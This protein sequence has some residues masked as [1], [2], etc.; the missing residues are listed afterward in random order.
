[1]KKLVLSFLTLILLLGCS[2]KKDEILIYSEDEYYNGV[3]V[4]VNNSTDLNKIK[5][6]KNKVNIY[7]FWGNGCPHC[8]AEYAFFEKIKK[9][10]GNY[11]NLYDFETWDNKENVKLLAEFAAALDEQISG[12]PYT[13]IGNQSVAGFSQ[14][15]EQQILQL[16]ESQSKN[17][18][19]I[20]FDKIKNIR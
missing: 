13:V 11:F 9:Q 17:S 3:S 20:Y 6:E 4:S 7:F 1:M 14:D 2:S 19:D 8:A 10:Y 16:I 12:V 18:Y 5:K 15:A